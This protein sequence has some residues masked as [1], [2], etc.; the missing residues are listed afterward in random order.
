MLLTAFFLTALCAGL[1]LIAAVR[2][3]RDDSRP[4]PSFAPLYSAYTL[5][6]LALGACALA[7]R[8]VAPRKT[9]S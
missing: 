5:F 6:L 8:P 2:P 1:Y 7:L 9:I 4:V 3:F